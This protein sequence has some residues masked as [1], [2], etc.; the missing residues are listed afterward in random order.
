L[1]VQYQTKSRATS[2][3]TPFYFLFS[4]P[5]LGIQLIKTETTRLSMAVEL[6]N[7]LLTFL[8]GIIAILSVIVTAFR[9]KIVQIQ[10][11]TKDSVTSKSDV[12][13]NRSAIT[14]LKVDEVAIEVKLSD[15]D[16]RVSWLEGAFDQHVRESN[17]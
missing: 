13:A 6:P 14:Q 5:L 9:W 16:K 11:D 12:K 4:F 8:L 7:E 10:N 15:L 2:S 17:K 3:I 1:A